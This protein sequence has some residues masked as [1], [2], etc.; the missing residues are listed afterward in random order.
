VA[1]SFT[2]DYPNHPKVSPEAAAMNILAVLDG[3]DSS[4]TGN[5]FD[6]ASRPVPW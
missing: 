4:N 6:W 2:D 5:F 3:L 1:T